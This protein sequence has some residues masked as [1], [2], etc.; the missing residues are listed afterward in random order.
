MSLKVYHIEGV[1]HYAVVFASPEEAVAQAGEG[2]LVGDW[3]VPTAVEVPLPPGYYLAYD[4]P[5]P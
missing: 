3:E 4:P 5:M 1:R 2:K